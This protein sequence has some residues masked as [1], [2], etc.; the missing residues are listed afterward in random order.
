M[1]AGLEA[2]N[3]W[4]SE[5]KDYTFR[6]EEIL[7]CGHFSQLVWAGSTAAGFGRAT[8]T[9]R[10]GRGG[11]TVFVVGQYA[12]AG[13]VV[14]HWRENVKPARDGRTDTVERL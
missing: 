3:I 7:G 9:N 14:G 5:I 1:S 10:G 2:T 12:P 6:G 4:Y 13:N 11:M 8:C